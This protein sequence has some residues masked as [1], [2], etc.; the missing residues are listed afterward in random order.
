MAWMTN[1]YSKLKGEDS[2]AAFTGKP[3]ENFGLA[4]RNEATGYGGVVILKKLA[5]IFNLKPEKTTLAIQGFGNVGSNFAQFAYKS[6]FKILALSEVEGGVYVKNGL[7]PE[8]TLRCREEKGKISGCYCVGSVCDL[9]FGK[10]ISN[11]EL[12]EMDVDVLV[13]AAVENVIT[14]ENASKIRAKYII[15]MAN[16]PVTSEAQEILENR[17][18]VSV[19]DILANS[20]G[21]VAS[22]FEWLQG[23]ERKLWEKERVFQE[24]SKVLENS[25]E[26]VFNLAK[27][28]KINLRRAAEILA[29]ERVVKAMER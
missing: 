28:E 13:P 23:K 3:L 7:D 4:G 6:G 29:V 11:K 24:L 21:V 9:S 22:Y 2:P 19:P 27:K 17:G 20:G 14:K 10:G 8:A 25:F 26:I 15:E 16:G 5:E 12:L 1:E 18:I